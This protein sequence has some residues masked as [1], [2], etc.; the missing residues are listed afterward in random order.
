[1]RAAPTTA[2]SG[3]SDGGSYATLQVIYNSPDHAILNL[4][5]TNS[6]T[7]VWWQGGSITADAEI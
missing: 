4:K 7:N 1:M 5:S 2:V 3:G 6:N